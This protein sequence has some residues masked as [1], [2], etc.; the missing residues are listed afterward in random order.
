M[1]R[2]WR[3]VNG[4]WTKVPVEKLTRT[5]VFVKNPYAKGLWKIER[6]ILETYGVAR[7]VG[8]ALFTD[9][10]KA[11]VENT[12]IED[13]QLGYHKARDAEFLASAKLRAKAP[14]HTA[15]ELARLKAEMDAAHPD[16]GGSSDA[17]ISARAAYERAK[18]GYGHP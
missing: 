16:K 6:N 4:D 3:C 15:A 2:L 14:A 18:A 8:Q 10:G 13:L 11:E 17:F 7:K 12:S 5:C 1:N 9:A